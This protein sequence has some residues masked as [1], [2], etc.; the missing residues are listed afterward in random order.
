MNEIS[1]QGR[2]HRVIPF[3]RSAS[4]GLLPSARV[5]PPSTPV[6]DKLVAEAR[7]LDALSTFRSEFD[8]EMYRRLER[9]FATKPMRGGFIMQT[10]FRLANSHPTCQQCLY[11]FEIDRERRKIGVP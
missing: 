2:E 6:T 1:D 7:Q 4:V 10:G 9:R 8:Y 3:P 11:A 5:E